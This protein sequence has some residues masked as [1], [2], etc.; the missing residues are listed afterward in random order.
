MS[1]YLPPIRI[2][3]IFNVA[4]FKYQYDFISYFI[5]DNHYV[6]KNDLKI[7]VG[8]TDYTGRTGSTGYTGYTGNKSLIFK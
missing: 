3:E 5:G 8:P 2:N 1:Q 6:K 4:D 7:I